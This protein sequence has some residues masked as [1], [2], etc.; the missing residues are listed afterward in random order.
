ML[1]MLS[2]YNT[3]IVPT[4]V[5]ISDRLFLTDLTLYYVRRVPSH[6]F[7]VNTKIL[8]IVCELEPVHS[9]YVDF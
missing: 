2:E 5:S 8:H 4:F 7:V 9:A 6:K 3:W 1:S